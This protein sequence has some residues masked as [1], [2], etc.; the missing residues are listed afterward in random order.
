MLALEHRDRDRWLLR[1]CLRVRD[2]PQ[3]TFGVA[4]RDECPGGYRLAV[5]QL[6]ALAQAQ[7]PGEKLAALL[8][9]V[10][11]IYQTHSH[12]CRAR[13]ERRRAQMSTALLAL[14]EWAQVEAEG[15]SA[16]AAPTKAAPEAAPEAV[17]EVSASTATDDAPPACSCA[18][19]PADFFAAADAAS[20]SLF[21][22]RD[23]PDK[24][25]L[26]KL[27]RHERAALIQAVPGAALPARGCRCLPAFAARC[28]AHAA[29]V[30]EKLLRPA[31]LAAD[32]LF[33]VF[34]YVLARAAC[35][36][37]ESSRVAL[38]ELCAGAGAMGE[39]GYYVTVLEAAVEYLYGLDAEE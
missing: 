6:Q 25:L 19:L 9:T 12:N 10:R 11:L 34:L 24:Y 22:D 28:E 3:H 38:S 2:A 1:Q 39:A 27:D 8:A 29:A 13:G 20:D 21:P 32:D 35:P 5:A 17:S 7:L 23:V 14:R 16:E 4:P 26:R 36:R 15:A 37:L 33:P 31:V 30:A 18:A